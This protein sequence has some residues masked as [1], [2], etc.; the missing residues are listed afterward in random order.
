MVTGVLRDRAAHLASERG[1][2]F[3]EWALQPHLSRYGR[4]LVP[5][6]HLG[7]PIADV[8]T[9]Y[10]EAP[11][12]SARGERTVSPDEMTGL[13]AL[14]RA[15]PGLSPRPGAKEPREFEDM[16]RGTLSFILNGSIATSL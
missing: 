4:S 6:S 13:E 10:R 8:S 12:R 9:V 5:D 14:E 3:G 7:E 15:A 1:A 16:H 11:A 2:S